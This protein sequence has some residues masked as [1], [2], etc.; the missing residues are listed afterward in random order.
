MLHMA[1]IRT[2]CESQCY[3]SMHKG[4]EALSRPDG[5]LF[6][7]PKKAYYTAERLHVLVHPRHVIINRL[8]FLKLQCVFV[9]VWHF[10]TDIVCNLLANIYTNWIDLQ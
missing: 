2:E 8:I 7:S 9:V 4:S 3:S 1:R 10:C 6:I 5:L